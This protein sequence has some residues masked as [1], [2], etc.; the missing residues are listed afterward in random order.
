MSALATWQVDV[1]K[2]VAA[3]HAKPAGLT[4]RWTLESR[5]GAFCCSWFPM[6]VARK[7]VAV[8]YGYLDGPKAG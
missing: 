6:T 4:L 8:K 1:A 3:G 5:A 7:D 2:G